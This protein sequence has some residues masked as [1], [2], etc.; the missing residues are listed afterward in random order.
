MLGFDCYRVFW[1]WSCNERRSKY[2]NCLLM[3]YH[4]FHAQHLNE[5]HLSSNILLITLHKSYTYLPPWNPSLMHY[6]FCS[7]YHW[8]NFKFDVELNGKITKPNYKNFPLQNLI[9]S[10]SF[11][12]S[13]CYV[14]YMKLSIISKEFQTGIYLHYKHLKCVTNSHNSNT[15]KGVL[16]CSFD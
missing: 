1:A 11:V 12:I 9:Q 14:A 5:N 6:V 4:I 3:L 13:L 16:I 8:W 15:C 7:C 10:I 2:L